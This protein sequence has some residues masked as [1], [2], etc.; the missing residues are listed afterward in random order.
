MPN[1][2]QT[3]E[4][5]LA[6]VVDNSSLPEINY[7]LWTKIAGKYMIPTENTFSVV[8]KITENNRP[9]YLCNVS[10]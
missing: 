3:L 7:T 10:D 8:N 9:S 6:T 5:I 2:M 1:L 4:D